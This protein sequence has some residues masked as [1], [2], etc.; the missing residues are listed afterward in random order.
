MDWQPIET[1]PRCGPVL[2]TDGVLVWIAHRPAM[3]IAKGNVTHWM[4]LPKPPTS[5]GA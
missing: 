3:V 5:G 1:C 2:V 4:P